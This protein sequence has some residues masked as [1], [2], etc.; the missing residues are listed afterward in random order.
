[1]SWTLFFQLIALIF[2]AGVVAV[3]VHNVKKGKK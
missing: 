2:F 1:M 3:A